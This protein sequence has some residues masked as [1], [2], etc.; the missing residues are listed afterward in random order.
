MSS[1]TNRNWV[2]HGHLLGSFD[3]S[4]QPISN[5]AKEVLPI[6]L[7][8]FR[9]SISISDVLDPGVKQV[10]QIS[11]EFDDIGMGDTC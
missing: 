7:G 5:L 4:V 2:R 6:F 11:G 1:Y 10:S 3:K 8:K 9:D